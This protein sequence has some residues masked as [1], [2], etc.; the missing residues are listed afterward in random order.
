MGRKGRGTATFELSQGRNAD[1]TND[2]HWWPWHHGNGFLQAF[3]CSLSL[4]AR[5]GKSFC[6]ALFLVSVWQKLRGAMSRTVATICILLQ[7]I[8]NYPCIIAVRGDNLNV[9]RYPDNNLRRK[10]GWLLTM[11]TV[12]SQNGRY[13][14]LKYSSFPWL[15]FRQELSGVCHTRAQHKYYDYSQN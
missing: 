12:K 14:G 5:Y 15:Y 6:Y 11:T 10:R 7:L 1:L 8:C 4:T 2:C 9:G 13:Y 3:T